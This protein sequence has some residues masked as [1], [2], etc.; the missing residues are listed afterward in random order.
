MLISFGMPPTKQRKLYNSRV[1]VTVP[2]QT[3]W[4]WE[5]KYY[6]Y[7]LVLYVH[8]YIYIEQK[9]SELAIAEKEK[10]DDC[11]GMDVLST[12][13]HDSTCMCTSESNVDAYVSA[14]DDH[15]PLAAESTNLNSENMLFLTHASTR[16]RH[17]P[18]FCMNCYMYTTMHFYTL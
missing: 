5:S 3:K 10:S 13:S 18:L 15:E 12:T 8:V 2:R 14:G 16:P 9:Q 1:D 17:N 11:D 7:V 6:M 4:Y